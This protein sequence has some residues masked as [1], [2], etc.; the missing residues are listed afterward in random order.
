[1]KTEPSKDWT[2][3]TQRLPDKIGCG[4][5]YTKRVSLNRGAPEMVISHSLKNTGAKV[6]ETT[7]YNHNFFVIDGQ[8]SGPGIT[9]RFPFDLKA[10]GDLKGFLE[11]PGR[12][13]KWLTRYQYFTLN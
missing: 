7:Q 4:Y 10:K 11:V 3:F 12:T 5:L 6:I 13:E 9:I 1:V 2:E 8:P